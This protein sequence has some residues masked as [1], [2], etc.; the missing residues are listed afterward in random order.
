MDSGIELSSYILK[1]F[2]ELS[3]FDEVLIDK[4]IYIKNAEYSE[5]KAEFSIEKD[6]KLYDFSIEFA[7]PS[8]EKKLFDLIQEQPGLKKR[9]SLNDL[10]PSFFDAVEYMGFPLLPV[11]EN[12]MNIKT[13]I[14]DVKSAY[15][16]V[17][18]YLSDDISVDNTLIFL[19]NGI[20]IE[21]LQADLTKKQNDVVGIDGSHNTGE[22][23]PVF[24]SKLGIE[25]LFQFVDKKWPQAQWLAY[26]PQGV[27]F[28]VKEK[29]YE[30][31]DPSLY[32]RLPDGSEHLVLQNGEVRDVPEM[33]ADREN[34]I[35]SRRVALQE[36]GFSEDVVERAAQAGYN[37]DIFSACYTVRVP[38]KASFK[39][40]DKLLV[41]TQYIQSGFQLHLTALVNGKQEQEWEGFALSPVLCRDRKGNSK[42]PV[43]S[44]YTQRPLSAC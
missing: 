43:F 17:C 9:L 8:D 44:S 37:L 12:Q 34:V 35:S 20:D 4:E 13:D 27:Y 41:I 15:V 42:D 32:I 19:L 1:K 3:V 31:T 33:F 18:N 16:A 29:K 30:W 11:E 40:V 23:P 2:L 36:A 7:I 24:L 14:Q 5:K 21:K 10:N 25:E 22:L 38:H 6:G 39:Y 28:Y 26:V